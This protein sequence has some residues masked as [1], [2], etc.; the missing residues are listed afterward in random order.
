ML[1]SVYGPNGWNQKV[2]GL[3]WLVGFSI[4]FFFKW[5]LLPQCQGMS[6][7]L[8]GRQPSSQSQQ[9]GEGLEEEWA[10]H[11]KSLVIR[12]ATNGWTPAATELRLSLQEASEWVQ[13]ASCSNHT[14]GVLNQCCATCELF[15]WCTTR[16]LSEEL[17]VCLWNCSLIWLRQSVKKKKQEFLTVKA[18]FVLLELF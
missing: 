6:G 18:T 9:R 4:L 8:E 15:N 14:F 11:K 5:N 1:P 12:Q 10:H 3:Y 2:T 16:T 13:P 17:L 7:G